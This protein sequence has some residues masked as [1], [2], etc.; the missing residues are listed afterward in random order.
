MCKVMTKIKIYIVVF[1]CLVITTIL[2]DPYM[3]YERLNAQYNNT[4]PLNVF[5]EMLVQCE[6]LNAPL[7][8]IV[9]ISYRESGFK[10]IV[11]QNGNDIGVM[12]IN[13]SHVRPNEKFEDYFNVRKN[14]REGIRTYLS[15]LKRTNG[16]L[17]DALVYY[18]AGERYNLKNYSETQWTGYVFVI[19]KNY[20]ISCDADKVKIKVD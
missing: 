20:R 3:K 12:Q 10:N 14:I 2:Q 15:A 5:V 16:N 1:L 7:N 19:L 13:R 8:M 9:S 4:L 17:K 11:G 6:K 18:N